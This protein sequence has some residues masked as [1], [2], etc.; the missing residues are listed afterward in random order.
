MT[1]HKL[2]YFWFFGAVGALSPFINLYFKRLGFSGSEIGLLAAMQPLA[3]MIA[4]P[5]AVALAG[6]LQNTRVTLPALMTL[7]LIPYGLLL[8]VTGFWPLLALY[9]A[10]FLLHAP[11]APLLDDATLRR[12]EGTSHAYGRIRLW[13][14]IGFIVAVNVIGPLSERLDLRV[15]LWGNWFA[16]LMGA[17]VA[18]HMARRGALLPLSTDKSQRKV[19][20]ALASSLKVIRETP[21]VSWLFL[22]GLLA[23]FAQVGG[24]NFFG[25]HAD[26]IGMSES[27][28]GLSWG[29]AV[30]S[31]V[32]MMVVSAPLMQRITARGLFILSALAGAIRWA[33]YAK[34]S[35]VGLLLGVQ[36]LH[37]F[38]FAAFHIGSVTLVHTLFPPERRTEGQSAWTVTTSGLPVLAG[39]YLAGYLYDVVGIRPLFWI[40]AVASLLAA[41][42]ALWIPRSAEPSSARPAP[43]TVELDW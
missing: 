6:R 9:F 7:S 25:I 34:T 12:I 2:L 18:W 28:I 43:T 40:S 38:T 24:T 17:L 26:D 11:I 29:I 5:L 15:A 30:V 32:V 35:S 13:G 1:G 20:R 36:V 19:A 16:L 42:V 8:A 37:A 22:A 3:A 21:G 14:S 33:V 39:T 41:L 10:A 4:P 23:R 27:L 31:E